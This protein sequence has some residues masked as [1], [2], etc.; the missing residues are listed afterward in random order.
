[1]T[2]FSL[3]LLVSNW[4]MARAYLLFL[5]RQAEP[6]QTGQSSSKPKFASQKLTCCKLSFKLFQ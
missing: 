5:Q 6:S 1:L 3:P 2:W 4:G